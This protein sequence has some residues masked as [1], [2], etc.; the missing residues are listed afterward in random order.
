M[1]SAY[2]KDKDFLADVH[3]ASESPD[4]FHLWW[5]GQSG[6]LIK[7]GNQFILLDP[8]L[9]DSLTAK[10]SQTEKPH[11]RVTEQVIDPINLSF[12]DL[13]TSSH[14][15][16]DHLDGETLNKISESTDRNIK[17]VL[18]K[19]NVEFANARLQEN[20]NIQLVGINEH[21]PI[22][23]GDFRING[24]AAA[25]NEIERDE[26]GNPKFMGLIIS[27]GQWSIYHS[28][29]TLWHS[30]LI[31]EL[32]KFSIDIA[33]VP[34]NGNKPERKVAGNLNGAEAAAVSKAVNAKIAIPHHFD[35][36]EFNT[37]N[38]EEFTTTCNRLDQR[39][40]VL[41]NGQRWSFS[42]IN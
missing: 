34:I 2:K 5:L 37:A 11:V 3:N 22:T 42:E 39:Y 36:F 6:F 18:P 31:S 7:W 25:H 9:S 10:Y 13:V 19:A 15:H 41:Q 4:D 21:N 32:L 24:I 30:E 23:I 1:K 38:P 14:N 8:Y 17:L 40:K 33:I 16:T 26:N 12:V 35:M 28:G 27:F 29:D 20:P